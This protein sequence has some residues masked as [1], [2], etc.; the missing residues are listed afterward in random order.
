MAGSYH[1]RV[2]DDAQDRVIQ[3]LRRHYGVGTDSGAIS[4]LLDD[5]PKLIDRLKL[6]EQQRAR[7]VDL[8]VQRAEAEREAAKE[9]DAAKRLMADLN[10]FAK[11]IE[12]MP[13]QRRLDL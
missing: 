5:W 7:L 10:A 13:R 9:T 1:V 11:G 3:Q 6:A 12:K 8:I 2:H 4:A